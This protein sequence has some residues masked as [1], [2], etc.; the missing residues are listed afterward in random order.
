[1]STKIHHGYRLAPDTDLFEFTHR[2]R[3]VLNPVRDRIDAT[4]LMREAVR[5]I[6]LADAANE[7]R[8]ENPLMKA[9]NDWDHTQRKVNDKGHRQAEESRD[10]DPHR[11]LVLF[12]RDPGTDLIH[13]LLFA[14]HPDLVTAWE[15]LDE[16][17]EYGYWNNADAPDGVTETD[18]DE[19]RAAWERVM[20]GYQ[21]PVETMLSFRL[22]GEHYDIGMIRLCGRGGDAE[23]EA[24]RIHLLTEVAPAVADRALSRINTHIVQAVF[25]ASGITKETSAT[26]ATG[27]AMTALSLLTDGP[28]DLVAA[29]LTAAE[30]SLDPNAVTYVLGNQP[31]GTEQPPAHITDLGPIRSAAASLAAHAQRGQR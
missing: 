7:P 30:A 18:W 19:R 9:L 2:L 1:M 5:L 24:A 4:W 21:P 17:E 13:A 20:P 25:D 11:F 15:S 16:V 6:D 8:P 22:R 27:A 10:F 23:A 28:D 12:G 29:L 14:E 31:T 3:T 26:D